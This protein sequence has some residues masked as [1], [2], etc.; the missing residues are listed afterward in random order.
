MAFKVTKFAFERLIAAEELLDIA[1]V[2]LAAS[3]IFEFLF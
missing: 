1:V 3:E 2:M